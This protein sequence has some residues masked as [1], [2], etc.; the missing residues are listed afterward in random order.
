MPRGVVRGKMGQERYFVEGVEVTKEEWDATFP[1]HKIYPGES[2]G[3]PS[4]G[5]WPLI[6]DAAGVHPEQIED[7]M[8]GAKNLG[9]PTD[10]TA[11]GQAIF[12]DR[13]HRR[14]FLRAH[15]YFDKHGGYGDG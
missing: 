9:V 12:R 13:D 5:A 1:D 15:G 10:F 14:R 4:P 6:S 7:A 8:Q 2:L 3:T 11:E